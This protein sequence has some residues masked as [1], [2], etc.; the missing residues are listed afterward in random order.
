M[1]LAPCE[2]R[3]GLIIQPRAKYGGCGGPTNSHENL[4]LIDVEGPGGP[5]QQDRLLSKKAVPD[6]FCSSPT[7]GFTDNG[8]YWRSLYETPT[9]E[10][11][12]ER[13][14][15]QL[16]PLYL[17]LHAY[18]RRALYRK[19]GAEHIN[20]QGPIPA[21]LLG[22]GSARAELC[23]PPGTVCSTSCRELRLVSVQLRLKGQGPMRWVCRGESA[24]GKGNTPGV[25]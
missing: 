25:T 13:L 18:V 17:N 10:E 15:L 20:L 2:Q 23:L 21:H 14:Y 7:A 12:L 8:A 6:G 4:C 19:Y 16:Q 9:F 24:P 22:K 3:I 1:V 5:E 11:D